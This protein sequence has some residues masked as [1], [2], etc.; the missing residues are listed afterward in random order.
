M[1]KLGIRASPA[2]LS[3]PFRHPVFSRVESRT[4]KVIFNLF[5]CLKISKYRFKRIVINQLGSF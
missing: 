1:V 5:N 3:P 4:S 2:I